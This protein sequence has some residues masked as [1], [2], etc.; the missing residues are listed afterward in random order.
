[1]L[2]SQGSSKSDEDS[3]VLFHARFILDGIKEGHRVPIYVA[4]VMQISMG[5]RSKQAQDSSSQS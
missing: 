2:I 4:I 5:L 3:K 1:M